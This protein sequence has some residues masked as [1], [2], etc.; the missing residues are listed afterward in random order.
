[1][2]NSTALRLILA[3]L[4]LPVLQSLPSPP[5][6][7]S[8]RNAPGYLAFLH[9]QKSLSLH[10]T[11]LL[12]ETLAGPPFNVDSHTLL[13][14]TSADGGSSVVVK[15]TY[16]LAVSSASKP[17]SCLYS[18][19]VPVSTIVVSPVTPPAAPS[20]WISLT[21]LLKLRRTVD[22]KIIRSLWHNKYDVGDWFGENDHCDGDG[23]GNGNNVDCIYQHSTPLGAVITLLLNM[24]TRMMAPP[25]PGSAGVL[26]L[27]LHN[28]HSRFLVTA[29]SLVFASYLLSYALRMEPL[30]KQLVKLFMSTPLYYSTHHLW[31]LL[32]HAGLPFKLFIFQTLVQLWGSVEKD[33]GGWLWEKIVDVE[34]RE[35]ER[36]VR[37]FIER[38]AEA[39]RVGERS[40]REEEEEEEAEGEDYED[41]EE[42]FES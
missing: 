24:C 9:K 27:V 17:L 23:D 37:A 42:S 10:R 2:Q 38:D 8:A 32:L 26:A 3:L 29:A 40:T 22:G 4:C 35:V 30:L 34:V 1:M 41:E 20:E 18:Y 13:Q 31:S 12:S 21:T 5:S 7:P 36:G 16:C 39:E 6:P 25:S 28:S 14:S 33:V 19:S 15:P 11:L